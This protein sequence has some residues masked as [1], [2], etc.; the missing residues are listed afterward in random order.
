M[1]S[2]GDGERR[3]AFF[4]DSFHEVNG[5]ALTS[6]EFVR[7][8]RRQ[9]RPMFSVH[10]GARTGITQEGSVTTFE[11]HRGLVRWQLE[12]DLAMDLVALRYRSKLRAALAEFKPDLVHIT[13][14]SDSGVLGAFMAHDLGVPLVASWH[15]NLHEFGARR[16]SKVLRFLPDRTR[17]S[18]ANWFEVKA[19]DRCVWFY[20]LAKL[21]FAPNAELVDMLGRR[22]GRPAFL[23]SRGIDTEL[24]SPLRRM[25]VDH[26]FVIG[27]VGRLSPEKNVRMLAEIERKLIAAGLTNYRFLIV[28]DGSEHQHLSSVMERATLPGILRGEDLARAYASMDAFVFPSAT[29]TF[30]NVVLEAMASG[31]PSIVTHE[32]GPKYLIH[33]GENGQLA[34]GADEFAR[35]IVEWSHAPERLARMRTAARECAEHYS[36]DAVWE[37]VY[38]RY[39][40]CFPHAHNAGSGGTP[41]PVQMA[42]ACSRL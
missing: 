30:G 4:T 7:F 27:Y 37:D 14:P 34:E 13:G 24:F 29:D 9:G 17:S 38:R 20:G 28:G 31:V 36:W 10:A 32:G 19:L 25:R 5:V 35:W 18:A 22:T 6:R 41:Q 23:M 15:T 12:R 2:N 16:L 1:N 26:D 11:F 39:E 33:P 42:V 40:L 21:I 3:V 8:T